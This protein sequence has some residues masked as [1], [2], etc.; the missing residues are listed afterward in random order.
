VII[1]ECER[2]PQHSDL[3]RVALFGL[4]AN[5]FKNFAVD[6]V[7]LTEIVSPLAPRILMC[8]ART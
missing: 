7:E 5:C 2:Q 1:G 8:Y 6:K 3:S 4:T